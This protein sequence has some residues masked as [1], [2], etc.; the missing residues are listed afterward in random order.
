MLLAVWCALLTAPPHCGAEITVFFAP[1]RAPLAALARETEDAQAT[2]DLAVYS[3]SDTR[4]RDAITNAAKRGVRVRAL[5]NKPKSFTAFANSLERAG[6]DVRYV[7][8]VMHHKFAIVDGPQSPAKDPAKT[9][10]LTGSCNWTKSSFSRYDEDLISAT[11]EPALAVAFQREFDLL[12]SNAREFGETIHDAPPRSPPA[13]AADV[14]FTSANMRAYDYRGQRSFKAKVALEQ[15]VCGRRLIAAIDGARKSVRVAA[16]HFRRADV[17]AALRRAHDRGVRVQVLLDGQE[18]HSSPSTSIPNARHD[19][20]LAKNGVAVRYKVYSERWDYRTAKQMHCK[21]TI[22]DDRLV[23]TGRFNL[24]AN[25]E[26]KTMENLLAIK[27][28]HVVNLYVQQ[29]DFMWRYGEGELDSL[30][31]RIRSQNRKPRNF[32]PISMTAAEIVKVRA[33]YER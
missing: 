19:E 6:V 7:N 27:K 21:F 8:T 29:F 12:W 14:V 11:N 16:T 24:S 26:L 15:G 17:S 33:A 28:P 25:S 13:R 23:L 22:V 1:N 10:V 20:Q 32:D 5:L 9:V 2:I 18:F 4:L 30:I 3:F 31:S